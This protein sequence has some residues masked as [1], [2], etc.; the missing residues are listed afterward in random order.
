MRYNSGLHMILGTDF[1]KIIEIFFS[2]F[3]TPSVEMNLNQEQPVVDQTK[4]SIATPNPEPPKVKIMK[5]SKK[6]RKPAASQEP[7]DD[8]NT[9]NQCATELP[10]EFQ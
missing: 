1:R 2:D 4:S 9:Q 6:N 10:K 3:Q 5:P 8:S 7:S